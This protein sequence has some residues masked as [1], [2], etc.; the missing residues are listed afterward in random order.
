VYIKDLEEQIDEF[1]KHQVDIKALQE[2]VQQL[3]VA[4]HKSVSRS[5]AAKLRICNELSDKVTEKAKTE[6][7]RTT[8]FFSCRDDLDT[9]TEKVFNMLNLGEK[10]QQEKDSWVITYGPVV[11]AGISKK[12][13]YLVAELKKRATDDFLK[14]G[15]PLPPVGVLLACAMRKITPANEGMFK[16]YWTK[17][18]AKV[19]NAKQWNTDVFYYYTPSQA[20]MDMSN[21]E[22]LKLFTVN[23]EA[24][25]C[26][27]WENNWQK[28][29]TQFQFSTV[30]ENKGK[31]QPNIPGKWTTSDSGQ[32]EWGGW[33]EDG[34]KMFNTRKEEIRAG[35][36]GR[37]E[38]IRA[39]EHKILHE[40]REEAGIACDNPDLQARMNRAKKRK[41][42]ADQPVHEVRAYKIIRTV[43]EEDEEEE[44]Q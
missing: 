36:K 13:N 17:I 27:V 35:R 28:W 7:W 23:H 25:I 1:K 4:A 21:P 20:R 26:L 5:K 24:M 9:G 18:L 11:K 14:K 2:Q 34:L 32:A 30:P 40:L 33:S 38:E 15:K 3:E 22:S 16:W 42:N 19:V 12:R 37:W 29:Q 10:T 8:K 44:E 39:F 41:L 31:K 43:D 6:L